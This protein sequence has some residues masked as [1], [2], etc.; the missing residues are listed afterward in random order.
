[1]THEGRRKSDRMDGRIEDRGCGTLS[2]LV[3]SPIPPTSV[4]F[5]STTA[6]I[7][8]M[9]NNSQDGDVGVRKCLSPAAY[10][11]RDPCLRGDRAGGIIQSTL[12]LEG[13]FDLPQEAVFPLNLP[14]HVLTPSTMQMLGAAPVM[15]HADCQPGWRSFNSEEMVINARAHLRLHSSLMPAEGRRRRL[16]TAAAAGREMMRG[17]GGERRGGNK[18]EETGRESRAG[19]GDGQSL[20]T[21]YWRCVATCGGKQ[22]FLKSV[23]AEHSLAG[24]TQKA[25]C[26]DR[27]RGFR[28]VEKEVIVVI[29]L[30][31]PLARLIYV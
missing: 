7:A 4:A 31:T 17:R 10:R 5:F 8:F 23:N 26:A 6:Y 12:E 22:D 20:V 1:M 11:L 27:R 28:C 30:L 16:S 29:A 9:L 21:M 24:V 14:L 25:L 19:N 3:F 13:G 2:V 15:A 18:H